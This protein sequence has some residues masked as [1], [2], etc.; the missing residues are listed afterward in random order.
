MASSEDEAPRS[1][2]KMAVQISVDCIDRIDHA[3]EA[4]GLTRPR[5]IEH[6]IERQSPRELIR[7]LKAEKPTPSRTGR[8]KMSVFKPRPRVG[9]ATGD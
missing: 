4:T 6:L 8:P 1:R 5:I 9:D 7:L 2:G 3:A